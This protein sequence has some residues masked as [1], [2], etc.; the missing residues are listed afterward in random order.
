MGS[1]SPNASGLYDISGNV[2]EWVLDPYTDGSDGLR[3]VRGGG[4]NSA[5]PEVLAT[6]YRN[7]VPAAS[8]ES[9]YGFRYV[10]EDTGSPD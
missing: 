1:F 6:A 2:W 7:P 3:V 9:F 5:D 8:K 10:L 4:W